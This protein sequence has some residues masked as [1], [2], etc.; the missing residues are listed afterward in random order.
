MPGKL[1]DLIFLEKPILALTPK[2][3]ETLRILGD[4][5]KYHARVNDE[6]D[7]LQTLLVLWND[8]KNKNLKLEEHA[9][10]KDYISPKELNK[11]INRIIK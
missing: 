10:L 4:A 3:S 2:K 1:A 6:D 8:W 7:I 11:A 9:R 5:H